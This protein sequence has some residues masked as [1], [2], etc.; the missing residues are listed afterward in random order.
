MKPESKTLYL[1]LAALALALLAV[2][3]AILLD[4]VKSHFSFLDSLTMRSPAPA[5]KHISPAPPALRSGK[6][7]FVAFTVKAPKAAKVALAGDFNEW[8]FSRGPLL[9]AK[10]GAWRTEIPLTPGHYC[11]QIEIDGK[12]GLDPSAAQT[13]QIEGRT[14]SALTVD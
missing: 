6:L 5:Q 14:C 11:Y 3:S 13:K 2:P 4:A 10:D 7:V 9:K 12:A 1:L 8:D